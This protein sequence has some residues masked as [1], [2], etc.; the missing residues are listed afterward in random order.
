LDSG[1]FDE[2]STRPQSPSLDES[3]Q[4]LAILLDEGIVSYFIVYLI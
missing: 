4:A 3:S 2:A 1:Y